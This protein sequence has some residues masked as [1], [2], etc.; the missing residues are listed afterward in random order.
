MIIRLLLIIAF[1]AVVW[2]IIQ[3]LKS[4]EGEARKKLLLKYGLAV[5]AIALI[6]LAITG[7]I[8]WIGAIIGALIP[9]VRQAFPLL[10]K[11]LPFLQQTRQQA[12]ANSQ[13]DQYSARQDQY[14]ETVTETLRVKVFLADQ[15]LSGEVIK[16]PFAGLN[17]DQLTLAQLEML[18]QYCQQND[19]ASAKLLTRYLSQRFGNEW[20]KASSHSAT[21]TDEEAYALLGLK[22]G[23][24]KEEITQAHRKLMQKVHPDRGGSDYLASKINQAK[25]LLLKLHT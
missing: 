21:M 17:F 12:N 7:R 3:Q 25:D 11:V 24:S 14:N 20:Q 5:A 10:L 19:P 23:A 9:I 4:S 2:S 18:L 22:P 1:I 6:L 8:H 15:A 16:G 13:Q